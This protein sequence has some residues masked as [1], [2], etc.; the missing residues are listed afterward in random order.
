[1]ARIATHRVCESQRKLNATALA[2]GGLLNGSGT[3]SWSDG[4]QIAVSGYGGSLELKYALS[5]ETISEWVS[6][7]TTPVPLG[8]CRAGV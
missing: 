4:S 3:L 7:S 5:G 2:R 6:I 1:M 8:G